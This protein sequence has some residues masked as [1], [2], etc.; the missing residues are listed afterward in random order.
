MVHPMP[1]IPPMATDLNSEDSVMGLFSGPSLANL[2]LTNNT[3]PN[4]GRRPTDKILEVPH[5][6]NPQLH[7]HGLNI[8][9]LRL[10]SRMPSSRRSF[11][12]VDTESA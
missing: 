3:R 10:H 5:A 8:C 11:S 7:T 12:R 1:N 2:T 4:N 9:M 6:Q